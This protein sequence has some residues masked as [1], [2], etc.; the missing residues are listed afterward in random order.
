MSIGCM[1]PSPVSLDSGCLCAQE[2][3]KGTVR[4]VR[5]VCSRSETTLGKTTQR[6][7]KIHEFLILSSSAC[8]QATNAHRLA[9]GTQ[10]AASE[11]ICGSILPM[12]R[13]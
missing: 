4:E 10:F 8:L 1:T 7:K 3:E 2:P 5:D 11:P 13:M 6:E 9:E 12:R